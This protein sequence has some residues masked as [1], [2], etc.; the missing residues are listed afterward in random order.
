MQALIYNNDHLIVFKTGL[1]CYIIYWYTMLCRIT[2][3]LLFYNYVKRIDFENQNISLTHQSNQL[4]NHQAFAHKWF[5]SFPWGVPPP[6]S[7]FC[8]I[9]LKT[10]FFLFIG[11]PPT[12]TTPSIVVHRRQWSL[13]F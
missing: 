13:I 6:P 2:N 11:Q 1:F 9:V 12:S 5:L 7:L 4:A 3:L 10:G 8:Y